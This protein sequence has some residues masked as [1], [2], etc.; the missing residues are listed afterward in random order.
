MI[1]KLVPSTIISEEMYVER[2]ADIQ[3]REIIRDMGRP[4]YILV[5]RQMGKTNLLINS[6]RKLEGINDIFAY[7][8]LSNKF[9]TDREC[10]RNIIDT[11][12]DVNFSKLE[13][14]SEKI[15][16]NREAR[17]I[18]AHREHVSELRL[19][20][21]A[22]TGKLII[23][24][25]EI[26]SLTA[27]EYSDKIFAQVRSVYFER[28]NYSE[29]ERL[30]YILSGVAEPSDIIKD[31]SISPFN[32]GQKILL[33][34]FSLEEFKTLISKTELNLTEKII[35]RIFY[36]ASG[37]P[38]LSWEICSK[39]EDKIIENVNIDCEVIDEIVNS[40]YTTNFD[41][42]PVDHIR[43]L[44]Q[45]DTE[46][47]EAVL[48]IYYQRIDD[49]S[50]KLKSR[51]YLAGILSS[52]YESGHIKIKNRI[53]EESLDMSWLLEVNKKNINSLVKA[54]DLYVKREYGKAAEIYANIVENSDF[55][56]SDKLNSSYKLGVCYSKLGENQKAINSLENNLFDKAG[57]RDIYIEQLYIIGLS[58][59]KMK[60]YIK[61][62]DYFN[63]IIIEKPNDYYYIALV[64]RAST[65]GKINLTLNR[66]EI[67][68]INE[69]VIH[70]QGLNNLKVSPEAICSA[71][72]NLGQLTE[73]SNNQASFD[74]YLS[75]FESATS[76]YKLK[77]LINALNIQNDEFKSLWPKILNALS[78][79]DIIFDNELEPYGM[80]TTLNE[81]A[82]LINITIELDKTRE[83]DCFL[84][85]IKN[86]CLNEKNNFSSVLLEIAIHLLNSNAKK[87]SKYILNFIYH[88]DRMY[89][90]PNDYFISN[91]YLIFIDRENKNAADSYFK[92]F[93]NYTDSIDRIDILLFEIKIMSLINNKDF[94]TAV[95]YCDLI[96]NLENHY[97]H[98]TKIQLLTIFVLK[99]R[100]L[101]RGEDRLEQAQ[102][103]KLII[104][105]VKKEDIQLE[106]INKKAFESIKNEVLTTI[107]LETPVQQVI[108][109]GKR[110]GRNEL[111][112]VIRESGVEETRKYKHVQ[113]DLERGFCKIM[114]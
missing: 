25:D 112:K 40:L 75:S 99:M 50:D 59:L 30:S 3:L 79:S 18:V 114:K 5:A 47:R 16:S 38:R 57:F 19:I 72:Y 80:D 24:L 87:A 71:Y 48:S 81:I 103:L 21:S 41:R 39:V 91:K 82:G 35:N 2:N 110:Y 31:K 67:I 107:V 13:N 97:S 27:A 22:I 26:D 78:S 6:K 73:D 54:E 83:L 63:K 102:K 105:K 96:I 10:F 53:I 104:D 42:P 58:Y 86:Y 66:K 88:L 106:H 64:N 84:E 29:F 76:S 17:N 61:S 12:L 95:K 69:E 34:D 15:Y 60:D 49:L 9:D 56:D 101:Q 108:R 98:D 32:I 68:S 55:S 52:D 8:D 109:K 74:Y 43:S 20:L 33:G 44:I 36:W 100:S 93:Q 37:N 77:P 62:E 111:V 45:S 1:K 85:N 94:E 92:G 11:I 90:S 65:L 4:G 28:V 23:N 46:L 51:L 89:I 14:I 70:Q 7:I 113:Q